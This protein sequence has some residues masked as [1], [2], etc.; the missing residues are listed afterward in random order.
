MASRFILY[1]SGPQKISLLLYKLSI[2]DRSEIQARVLFRPRVFFCTTM[3][4]GCTDPPEVFTNVINMKYFSNSRS[5]FGYQKGFALCAASQFIL[6]GS[7]T[8]VTPLGIKPEF[9]SFICGRPLLDLREKALVV[10]VSWS[11]GVRPRATGGSN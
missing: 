8:Y 4:F 3:L 10:G 9:H 5:Q 11:H 6:Y 7:N 1:G 2:A